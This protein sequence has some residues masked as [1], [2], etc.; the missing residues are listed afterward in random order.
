MQA[1]RYQT[2]DATRPLAPPPLI[3]VHV[4]NDLGVWGAGF[5]L[6]VSKRWPAVKQRYQAWHAGRSENS[7]PPFELGAVQFVE[8]EP[9]LQVANVIGQRGI[10]RASS[11]PAPVRYEAIAAGLRRV[12]EEAL[13]AQASVHMPRIGCGLAGGDW[14]KVEVI[15]ERELAALGVPVHVYDLPEVRRNKK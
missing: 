5:V 15:L 10:R 13:L 9:G 4:C 14:A 1:I 11:A 2:G 8:V 6:A 12:A 7:E 3:I